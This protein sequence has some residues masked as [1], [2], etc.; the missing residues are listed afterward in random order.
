[1]EFLPSIWRYVRTP[2]YRKIMRALHT[3]TKWVDNE[4]NTDLVL[5]EFDFKP[6][7]AS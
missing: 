6:Q 3:V 5:I 7:T 2:N 4:S 1:M